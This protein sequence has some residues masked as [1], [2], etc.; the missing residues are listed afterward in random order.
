MAF[1]TSRL[2]LEHAKVTRR[3]LDSLTLGAS[4]ELDGRPISSMLMAAPAGGLLTDEVRIT[5]SA[6]TAFCLAHA[7]V[8]SGL[9]QLGLVASWC[10]SSKID[11]RNVQLFR[12]DPFFMRPLGIDQIVADALYAQAIRSA[13]EIEEDEVIS[14][15]VA[16]HRRAA[17]NPRGV[18]KVLPTEAEIRDAP[19]DAIPV[20]RSHRAQETDGAVALIL[21]SS[22]FLAANPDCRPIARVTGVGWTTDSYQ[23]SADRLSGMNSARMAFS[24]ALQAAGLQGASEIDVFELETP[25]GWYEA[26]LA[27]ALRIEGNQPISPSGGAFAQYPSFCAG[28]VNVAEAVLQV[29]GSAGSVQCKNVRRAMAH[30]GHGL[31]QQGSVSI[32]LEAPEVLQ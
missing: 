14:R 2:A 32:I 21:A 25:T 15:V 26:G 11:S 8:K 12:D 28:L 22:R 18:S 24:M 30:S 10:K 9:S 19:Y 6:A 27:R 13:Y 17:E 3:Q 23:L 20:K 7:R 4:D 16:A 31:A 1:A 29:E 5:D